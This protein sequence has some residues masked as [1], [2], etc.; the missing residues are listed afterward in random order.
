MI[1]YI[2]VGQ[3]IMLLKEKLLER[4]P[5]SKFPPF[6][7]N[8]YLFALYFKVKFPPLPSSELAIAFRP[9]Y[10]KWFV[11]GSW[12]AMKQSLIKKEAK[13]ITLTKLDIYTF[14]GR[15]HYGLHQ[16]H[17]TSPIEVG[18]HLCKPLLRSRLTHTFTLL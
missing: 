13:K 9:P 3:F 18:K 16:I 1:L 4:I 10:P 6:F 12:M 7:T 2:L 11:C 14:R 8:I 15:L 5:T 17:I